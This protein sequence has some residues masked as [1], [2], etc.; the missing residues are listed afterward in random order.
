MQENTNVVHSLVHLVPGPVLM[1]LSWV[2]T[3]FTQY[4]FAISV[5]VYVD[6]L[7]FV[8]NK[9]VKVPTL[10]FHPFRRGIPFKTFNDK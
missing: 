9:V 10:L 5:T 3:S 6:F 1:L 4:N 2:S 8:L 7:D